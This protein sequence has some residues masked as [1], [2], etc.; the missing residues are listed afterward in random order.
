M[1]SKRVLKITLIVF[2][3]SILLAISTK[4]LSGFYLNIK[5]AY[6]HP[7]SAMPPSAAVVVK[8]VNSPKVWKD[9]SQNNDLFYDLNCLQD[10]KNLFDKIHYADSI[11]GE[12]DDCKTIFTENELYLALYPQNDSFEAL[13]ILSYK[14]TERKIVNAVLKEFTQKQEEK[15]YGM[16]LY[17]INNNSEK[18]IFIFSKQGLIVASPD[19][20]LLE[21][22]AESMKNGKN[23]Q[24]DEY[25]QKV[26]K[27][28]GKK[29]DLSFYLSYENLFENIDVFNFDENEK[30]YFSNIGKWVEAD[31]L[32]RKKMLILNGYSAH[33]GDEN[34]LTKIDAHNENNN[35]FLNYLPESITTFIA[36]SFN[37]GESFL[38][39]NYSDESQKFWRD[40]SISQMVKTRYF[41]L[42]TKK[43]ECLLF[44]KPIDN[45]YSQNKIFEFL[46]E[47]GDNQN[48]DTTYYSGFVMGRINLKNT[49]NEFDNILFDDIN[50]Q[51]FAIFD[52]IIAFGESFSQLKHLSE[53]IINHRTFDQTAVC[54]DMLE[55]ARENHNFFYLSL[56]ARSTSRTMG[57]FNEKY[58]QN[59]SLN[60]FIKNTDYLGLQFNSSRNKMTLSS[61]F[62]KYSSGESIAVDDKPQIQ[63]SDI[64][65]DSGQKVEMQKRNS[66]KIWEAN[67]P[68]EILNAQILTDPSEDFYKVAVLDNQ[69]NMAYFD[70]KG[71]KQWQIKL[72]S[73]AAGRITMLDYYKN[74][75]WQMYFN[76][77]SHIF[78]VDKLG[79]YVKNY[80]YKFRTK[81]VSNGA[82]ID[83]N[84]K[85][86]YRI[87]YLN[88]KRQISCV[89]LN[90]AMASNWTMPILNRPSDNDLY[91]SKHKANWHITAIDNEGSLYFYN[92]NGKESVRP[93]KQI[94]KHQNS[95]FSFVNDADPRWEYLS[96]TGF[97]VRLYENGK[98]TETNIPIRGIPQWFAVKTLE[99]SSVK[100][101]AALSDEIYVMNSNLVVEKS[102]KLNFIPQTK[103]CK[104][105]KEINLSNGN[106]SEIYF[107]ESNSYLS[108]EGKAEMSK[109]NNKNIVCSFQNKTFT[110]SEIE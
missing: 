84:N 22:S 60:S 67:M 86:D 51:T 33:D 26:A 12:N 62:M 79:R 17:Y 59:E 45:E 11:I 88:E 66:K 102:F 56:P 65:Y 36:L 90:T 24:S 72:K 81:V 14:K 13:L 109:I 70:H 103:E 49:S 54:A 71:N 9:V 15:F 35:L 48:V 43:E 80:P 76:S 8:G 55:Y 58:A 97:L 7:Y 10:F 95:N 23:L 6:L 1:R 44:A 5:E 73:S 52:S 64:N 41:N 27:T 31:V 75:K 40:I 19:I 16:T 3:I 104:S 100:Y 74:G 32:V 92:V 82:V 57:L 37:D 87:F 61:L 108:F 85:K 18:P 91:V 29:V 78:M 105:Y 46:A 101:F 34:I 98:I 25:F 77:D 30:N 93:T 50:I 83:L 42:E 110:I 63:V 89:D 99:N 2:G 106:I 47:S 94:K 39:K 69:S 28:S 53:Q 96:E 107:I 38:G 68:G 21:E 20:D 4:I